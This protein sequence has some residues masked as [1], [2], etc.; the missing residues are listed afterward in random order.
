MERL[1]DIANQTIQNHLAKL[2]R[3]GLIVRIGTKRD[4][5]YRWVGAAESG[6]RA[7]G[8]RRKEE[9]SAEDEGTSL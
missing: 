7:N 9:I 4:A 6:G 1:P 8:K 2:G 5:E 3:E